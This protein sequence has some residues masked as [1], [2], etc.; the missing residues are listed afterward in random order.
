MMHSHGMGLHD[1][2]VTIN[3]NDKSGKSVAFA[4]YHPEHGIAAPDNIQFPAYLPCFG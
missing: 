1:G 4:M 2:C 3:I